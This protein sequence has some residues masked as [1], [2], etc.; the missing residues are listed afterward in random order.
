MTKRTQ[1]TTSILWP[2]ISSRKLRFQRRTETTFNPEF[3]IS[4]IYFIRFENL[5]HEKVK[6]TA[7]KIIIA[8]ISG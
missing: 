3:R 1:I 7:L 8:R 2:A 4:D 5:S 6:I